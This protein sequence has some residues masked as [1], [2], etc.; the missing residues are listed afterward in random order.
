M[1]Q[2]RQRL[3]QLTHQKTVQKSMMGRCASQFQWKPDNYDDLR[4][5]NHLWSEQAATML[6]EVFYHPTHPILAVPWQKNP[7]PSQKWFQFTP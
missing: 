7:I 4:H 6:Q 5:D 3:E 1:E 2:Q